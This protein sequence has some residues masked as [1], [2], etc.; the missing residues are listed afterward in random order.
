MVAV[1]HFLLLVVQLTSFALMAI[2]TSICQLNIQ[3]NVI[4]LLL[5]AMEAMYQKHFNFMLILV[6][7]LRHVKRIEEQKL[8]DATQ[9][10]MMELRLL[11]PS[12][13]R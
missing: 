10:A 1:G 13:I 4:L 5:V 8:V 12:F 7:L 11:L 9:S 2:P 6:L 3:F